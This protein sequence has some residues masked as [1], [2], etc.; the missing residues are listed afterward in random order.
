[1]LYK[2]F[3]ELWRAVYSKFPERRHQ[4]FAHYPSGASA[5]YWFEFY[6]D[7]TES[8]YVNSFPLKPENVRKLEMLAGPDGWIIYKM[9]QVKYEAMAKSDLLNY[10]TTPDETPTKIAS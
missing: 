8:W 10:G 9:M 5:N 1:M 7:L 4:K 6:V 3:A 2:E